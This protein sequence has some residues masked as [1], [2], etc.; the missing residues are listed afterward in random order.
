MA[1]L[2]GRRVIA[3]V[4]SSRRNFAFGRDQGPP[5]LSNVNRARFVL[6]VVVT[7]SMAHGTKDCNAKYRGRKSTEQNGAKVTYKRFHRADQLDDGGEA[8]WPDHDF[9]L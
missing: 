5:L 7:S 6:Y 4:S 9:V 8:L 1:E 3:Q 2:V